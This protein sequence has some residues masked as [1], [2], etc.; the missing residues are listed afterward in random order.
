MEIDPNTY[1]FG[2]GAT[3]V[4]WIVRD[5]TGNTA[6]CEQTVTVEEHL[7]NL[8]A[9]AKDLTVQLD[10]SGQVTITPGQVDDGSNYGCNNT[11]NLSLDRDTFTCDDVDT[12]VTVTL[13]AT[14]GNNSDRATATVTVEAAGT[15][16]SATVAFTIEAIADVIIRENTVYTVTPVLSGN[17]KDPV[18]WTLGGTDAEAFSIDSSTGVVT[19]IARDFEAPADAD[20]N[21][22]YEVSIIATDSERNASETSWTV[23]VEE[24]DPFDILSPAPSSSFMIPTAFTPNG[25]GA[26]DT[27]IIDN[28]SEDATV[29]IYDRHGT[30]I[31]S[32]DVGYTR[33]WDGTSRGGSLPAGSYLYAIQ[34]GPNTYKGAVTILL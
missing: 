23:T 30:T 4:T 9:M 16:E 14:H 25:D 19:M 28:L 29:R 22:V 34:N 2:I 10:A 13:T 31:F 18:T 32:S 26:N 17:A 15:C 24:Y 1:A 20:A 12:P 5:G 3:S 27:W 8:V 33:P 11:P 7:D 6:S 21:N